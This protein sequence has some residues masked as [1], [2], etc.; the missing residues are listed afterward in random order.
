MIV[1]EKSVKIQSSFKEIYS[2]MWLHDNYVQSFTGIACVSYFQ[3]L[4]FILLISNYFNIN[5]LNVTFYLYDFR[6]V[7]LDFIL[8][9]NFNSS[10]SVY[11]YLFLSR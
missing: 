1:R 5:L 2:I 9:I 8:E 6:V 11:I 7:L 10:K 4:I 3:F